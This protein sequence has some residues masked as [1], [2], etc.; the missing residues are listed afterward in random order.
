[1]PEC[2]DKERTTTMELEFERD[3]LQGYDTVAELTLCQ[4]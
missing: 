4:E 1:M 2:R 3:T